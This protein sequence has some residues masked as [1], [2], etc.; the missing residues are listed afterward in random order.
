LDQAAIHNIPNL[1]GLA[2]EY[3]VVFRI[4]SF[5]AKIN[6]LAKV[7]MICNVI[8]LLTH[9]AQ[10]ESFTAVTET[11]AVGMAYSPFPGLP[12][13]GGTRNFHPWVCYNPL[14][15]QG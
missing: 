9:L 6:T 14:K 5:R 1:T 4:H 11:P 3:R 8:V 7:S 13:S 15:A 10:I 2:E 12:H